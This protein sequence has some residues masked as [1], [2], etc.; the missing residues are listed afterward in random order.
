MFEYS[1][2][3]H[4]GHSFEVLT[5]SPFVK[6]GVPFIGEILTATMDWDH[7]LVLTILFVLFCTSLTLAEHRKETSSRGVEIK[8]HKT[9]NPSTKDD[10]RV[11]FKN[12]AF[13]KETLR[14]QRRQKD[15][16]DAY[17]YTDDDRYNYEQRGYSKDSVYGY[18]YLPDNQYAAGNAADDAYESSL[19]PTSDAYDQEDGEGYSIQDL[20]KY[21]PR[22]P[23]TALLSARKK[24]RSDKMVFNGNHRK[25]SMNNH[26]IIFIIINQDID[27]HVSR[28]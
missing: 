27:I 18:E 21:I 15:A 20:Y 17:L 5:Y 8:Y 1:D 26:I 13:Y 28:P 6:S 9:K 16:Y 10:Y 3:K 7:S 4:W 11:V 22:S 19:T 14:P 12:K 23:I 25:R 24:V 2:F